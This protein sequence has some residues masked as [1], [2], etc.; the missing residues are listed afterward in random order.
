[1]VISVV[2]LGLIGGSIAMGLAE[3][4]YATEVIGFDLLPSPRDYFTARGIRTYTVTEYARARETDIWVLAVPP[5]S[6][7]S[8]IHSIAPFVKPDACV[9]DVA[10][11]KGRIMEAELPFPRQFI[12]GHPIAGLS[13][14]SH[15][16]ARSNLFLD[17]H[18]V[19]CDDHSPLKAQR[20][21]AEQMV[22][23]LDALP[24][25]MT[26]QQHDEHLALLSHVPHILATLLLQ[27]SGH[28]QNP[29]IGGGSW[30][31]LTRVGGNYPELWREVLLENRE[32]ILENLLALRH[33]LERVE[34]LLRDEDG[35]E[36]E[37]LFR[38]A[39]ETR[40]KLRVP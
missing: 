37:R 5:Q 24:V 10:S 4:G 15:T 8:V 28:L 23:A 33:E 40:T 39:H 13:T 27:Q 9:T 34:G 19:L 22:Y 38:R 1:M 7:V 18:W 16:Q 20:M 12:G 6:V 17:K 32:S 3:S 21:L 26:A 2:G 31:D 36:I 29:K 11:T 35:A 25:W 14:S 30:R